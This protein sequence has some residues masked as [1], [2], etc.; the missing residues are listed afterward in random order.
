MATD[1]RL[2]PL[3]HA[4]NAQTDVLKRLAKA[5]EEANKIAVDIERA[6]REENGTL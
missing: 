3:I 1:P 2:A 6:R 4:I 5:Q